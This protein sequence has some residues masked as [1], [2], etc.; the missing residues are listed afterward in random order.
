[1]RIS[2]NEVT[3]PPRFPTVT[4]GAKIISTMKWNLAQLI[5]MSGALLVGGVAASWWMRSERFNDDYQPYAPM[6][7]P[8]SVPRYVSVRSAK[9]CLR[10][11]FSI[12]KS[13]IKSMGS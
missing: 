3:R 4:N 6:H 11:P 1:V 2:R 10:I 8:K 13:A 7:R 12:S 5:S 9:L